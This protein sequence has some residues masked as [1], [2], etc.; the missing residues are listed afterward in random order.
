MNEEKFIPALARY[1][2]CRLE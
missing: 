1:D 2:V